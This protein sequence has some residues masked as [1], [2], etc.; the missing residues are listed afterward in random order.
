M[1][2]ELSQLWYCVFNSFFFFVLIQL[3]LDSIYTYFFHLCPSIHKT[4]FICYI[5]SSICSISIKLIHHLIVFVSNSFSSYFEGGKKWIHTRRRSIGKRHGREMF[6]QLSIV[7]SKFWV[8]NFF[9]TFY[10]N[11]NKR[12]NKFSLKIYVEY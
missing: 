8:F 5:K 11:K 2:H 10:L 1:P 7:L 9:V 3:K 4:Q 12:N 6:I